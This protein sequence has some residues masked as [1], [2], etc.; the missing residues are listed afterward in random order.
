MALTDLISN[1]GN[2]CG[3]KVT[4]NVISSTDTTTKQLLALLQSL[5]EELMEGYDWPQLMRSGSITLATGQSQ[6]SVPSDF[7]HHHYDTFWDQTQRWPLYGQLTNQEYADI[8][9]YGLD[10][11]ATTNFLI[12]GIVD[13]KIEISPPPT[14]SENGKV[15]YFLY[16]SAR[17]VKPI[18]WAQGNVTTSGDYTIYNNRYYIAQNSGTNSSTPPTHTTGTVSDGTINWLYTDNPYTTFLKDTDSP[19][20]KQRI[21]E[22]GLEEAFSGKHALEDDGSFDSKVLEEYRR[23]KPGSSIATSRDLSSYMFGGNGRMYI[24]TRL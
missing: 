24:G 13:K 11:A 17:Y 18:T 19:V 4:T 16:Q 1:V 20:M 22:K 7:S 23:L 9:G 5:N 10:P 8:N 2:K 12:T 14:S 3:Y 6:Y 15:V 21:V